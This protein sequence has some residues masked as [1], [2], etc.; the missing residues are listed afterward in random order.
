MAS[1][2]VQL[3]VPMANGHEVVNPL[4]M[5]PIMFGVIAFAILMFLLAATWAFRNSSNHR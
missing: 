3:T 5:H 2:L 1:T 4:P